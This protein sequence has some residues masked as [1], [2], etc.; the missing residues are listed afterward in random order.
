[1]SETRRK[2]LRTTGS[3]IAGSILLQNTN[4]KAFNVLKKQKKN[5]RTAIIGR[6]GK[7]NY[8]HGLDQV[9]K[10]I[11]NVTVVA[12]ADE[13][14]AGLKKAIEISGAKRQYLDYRE[15]LEKEKPDIVCIAPRLPDCHLD[16]AIASIEVGAN[17]YIEKPFTN[18]PEEAD[19]ILK[20]AEKNKIKIAV[21]HN[22]R[23]DYDIILLN[24]LLKEGFI[25]DALEI[26]A[27]GKEDARVGGEDLIVLGVHHLDIMRF[28]FDNPEWCFAS[29][30]KENRDITPNDTH[31]GREPYKVAGD[32]V[33]AE[34]SFKNNVQG[35]WVSVKNK[36][37]LRTDKNGGRWT[38]EEPGRW[39]YDIYV[40]R[41]IVS[42]RNS[43]GVMIFNSPSL[44]TASKSAK[45]EKIKHSERI[46]IPNYKTNPILSLINSI[47]TDTQPQCSGYDGRWTIE[48]VM[49]V[50]QSQI[51]K[52]R[53]YFPLKDRAHPLDNF[54]L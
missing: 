11:E 48:M 47:E 51:S 8:G 28:F 30:L 15:M 1:M 40:S 19:K 18:T 54:K 6:T 53:V 20:S 12:V 21:A 10:G 41:G 4:I 36:D 38:P 43:L 49:A 35:Y 50:Y 37:N 45:W 24:E 9:F 27:Q 23:Y 31:I 39:G 22:H 42:Y 52:K 7:G 14:P 17:I 33:R 26:R 29:V 34:Y 2:F 16:M 44:I 32:T 3:I 46:K 13:N 5:Y 25:G